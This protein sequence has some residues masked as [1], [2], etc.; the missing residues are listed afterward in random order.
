MA[1]LLECEVSIVYISL[2]I[3]TKLKKV[4]YYTTVYTLYM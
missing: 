4:L 3:L 1:K 2:S